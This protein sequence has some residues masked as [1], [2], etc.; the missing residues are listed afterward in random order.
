MG[1]PVYVITGANRGIGLALVTHV[2]Q[3]EK[4]ACVAAT[5]R[6][7]SRA[8]ELHKLR[9]RYE[10]RLQLFALDAND[11]ASVEASDRV[12]KYKSMDLS[13]TPH[14]SLDAPSLSVYCGTSHRLKSPHDFCNCLPLYPQGNNSWSSNFKP[15]MILAFHFQLCQVGFLQC[16]LVI[17]T[18]YIGHL[19]SMWLSV[20]RFKE[21]NYDSSAG[22]Q[23]AAWSIS[24]TFADGIDV[25][26]NN[27]GMLER[28]CLAT[29]T[30]APMPYSCNHCSLPRRPS[31][32]AR[33]KKGDLSIMKNED[34]G[35]QP[36]VLS[37]PSLSSA[38]SSGASIQALV[39]PRCSVCKIPRDLTGNC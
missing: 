17:Q 35:F 36:L 11:D 15:K 2:L 25:L 23:K 10:G 28:F 18:A 1:P 8:A 7:P 39:K 38:V 34:I 14:K 29:E 32:G 6:V 5:A 22:L 26:I 19:T 9:E 30:C 37:P 20:S 16:A 31:V 12:L 27:A 4:A 33:A 3:S 21:F 24:E 13:A